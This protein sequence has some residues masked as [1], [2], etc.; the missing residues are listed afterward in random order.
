MPKHQEILTK[1]LRS[2]EF[3]LADAE[4]VVQSSELDDLVEHDWRRHHLLVK[5]NVARIHYLLSVGDARWKSDSQPGTLGEGDSPILLRRLRKIGTVPDGFVSADHC[6]DGADRKR[7]SRQD[8]RRASVPLSQLQ[9]CPNWDT[10]QK[11]DGSLFP[12]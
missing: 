4:H 6:R 11:V 1:L 9:G 8:D 5:S 12:V 7:F 2:A 10:R 3:L